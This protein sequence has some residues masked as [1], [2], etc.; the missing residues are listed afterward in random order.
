MFFGGGAGGGEH[1]AHLHFSDFK[2]CFFVLHASK[3]QRIGVSD[4]KRVDVVGENA[5]L[6]ENIGI[7]NF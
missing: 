4:V 1:G 7:V 5:A 3:S 2:R 6:S